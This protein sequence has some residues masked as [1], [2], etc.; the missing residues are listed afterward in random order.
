MQMANRIMKF[1]WPFSI[2]NLKITNRIMKDYYD[3]LGVSRDASDDQIK[4][5]YK[6]I[7]LAY[8]PDRVG[9]KTEYEKKR[10]EDIVKSA[11]EAYDVLSDPEKRKE[12]DNQR[13]GNGFNPFED[14][15]QGFSASGNPANAKNMSGMY[16]KNCEVNLNLDISDFYNRGKKKVGFIKQFRCDVCGGEGGTG[17]KECEHCH[18]TGMIVES[19][20]QGNMFFQSSHQCPYC[21]GTGK[22]VEHKCAACSGTGLIGK[23]VSETIDLAKIPIE[24]LL[25]DGIRIDLGPLGSESK[26]KNGQSGHLFVTLRHS[27]DNSKYFILRNG[28]VEVMT[29]IDWK[30]LMLGEKIVI[31]IPDGTKM[32]IS[33]P[34]CCE[35]G[36]K[37]KIKN[38]GIDGHDY[39]IIV[40]PMFPKK[41]TEK[42]RQIIKELKTNGNENL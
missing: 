5:A 35:S 23:L 8:H 40:N 10:A 28:D 2:F 15:F 9:D 39:F 14:F 30:D 42:E 16:G 34:E 19:R 11:N 38:K 22:I 13:F 18:G 1:S 32:K 41:L 21:G 31:E 20:M 24:Y 25:Q 4:K 33:I 36:K 26:S 17:I 6:K 37:L 27:Y 7:M 12:Y 29:D 3:V